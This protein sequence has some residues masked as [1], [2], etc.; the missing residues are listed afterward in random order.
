ML[1]CGD[2]TVPLRLDAGNSSFGSIAKICFF[3]SIGLLKH[4]HITKLPA[5]SALLE[6]KQNSSCR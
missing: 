6:G 2:D 1:L 4:G 3:P 5:A